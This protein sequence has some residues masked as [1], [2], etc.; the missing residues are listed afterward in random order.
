M[1]VLAGRDEK[2]GNLQADQQ[3]DLGAGIDAIREALQEAAEQWGADW[4]AEADGGCL[5][6]PVTSGLRRGMVRARVTLTIGSGEGTGLGVR[7]EQ[8]RMDL[9]GPAVGLLL[10]GALGCAGVVLWPYFPRLLPLA[11]VG[12]LIA[13]A[14]WMMVVSR[15]RHSGVEEFLDLVKSLSEERVDQGISEPNKLLSSS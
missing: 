15:L 6:L 4:H 11:P 3:I 5:L 13:V 14:T 10:I 7:V 9:N 8:E 2:V 1:R 12:F